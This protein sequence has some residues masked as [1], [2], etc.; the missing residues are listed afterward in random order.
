LG[1]LLKID[2]ENE[3]FIGNSEANALTTRD[4]RAPYVV[5]KPEN[6]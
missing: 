2:V 1:P 4:Y 5:P 3:V 6:V